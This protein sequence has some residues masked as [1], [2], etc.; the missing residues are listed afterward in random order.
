MVGHKT[1]LSKFKKIEIISTIFSDHCLFQETE[2]R[3][4]PQGNKSQTLNN[5]EIEY[6]AIK[7][8]IGEEWD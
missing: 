2:T 4:K 7:Q 1:G 5:M 3:N 6:H 8:W